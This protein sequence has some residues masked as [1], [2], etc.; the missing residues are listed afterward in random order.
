MRY[1]T[2]NELLDL[3]RRIMEQSGGAMGVQNL[4][5]LESA[6]A[7]PHMTFGGEELYQ[8][9][10]EKAAALGFSL[11]EDHPLKCQKRVCYHG[12]FHGDEC[13]QLDL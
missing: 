3:Y 1:L 2:L 11:I 12:N 5:M 8:T 9:M 10:V 6:L 13:P 7:Q 4:H